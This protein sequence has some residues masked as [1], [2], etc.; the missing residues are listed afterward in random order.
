[1]AYIVMAYIVMAYIVMA[2]IVMAYIV[3][4][5][6]LIEP[7]LCQSLSC[8]ARLTRSALISA[9]STISPSDAGAECRF[10][11]RSMRGCSCGCV[12]ACV[13][14][15]ML[16]HACAS[17]HVCAC[18]RAHVCRC[19]HGACFTNGEAGG[20]L[21]SLC[22]LQRI[23]VCISSSVRSSA[24][25][26]SKPSNC[27][28]R[29]IP[30]A[31]HLRRAF[32]LCSALRLQLFQCCTCPC[33]LGLGRALCLCHHPHA[34][35]STPPARLSPPHAPLTRQHGA[36]RALAL[37]RPVQPQLDPPSSEP[38]ALWRPPSP[39]PS[40][41]PPPCCQIWPWACPAMHRP[42]PRSSSPPAAPRAV[43]LCPQVAS[44]RRRRAAS[45]RLVRHAVRRAPR[46]W[47]RL[48]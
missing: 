19:T 38:L 7:R 26:A 3:M 21:A 33:H 5:Y 40:R 11:V 41:A 24:M 29:S 1:M 37:R 47:Y 45:R 18:A 39:Q 4:A 17:R 44:S 25:P 15:C 35:R 36:A 8:S 6:A 30:S 43:H 22:A 32:H 16:V 27:R 9:A 13:R 20:C 34:A 48:A 12:R 14:A 2:Y 23:V 46:Q 31:A 10:C 28:S 42:Q